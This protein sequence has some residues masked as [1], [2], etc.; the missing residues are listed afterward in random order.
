MASTFW[1][2][3]QNDART[4]RGAPAVHGHRAVSG[5]GRTGEPAYTLPRNNMTSL[6]DTLWVR[7]GSV[8]HMECFLLG[9]WQLRWPLMT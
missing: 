7:V 1:G 8:G 3:Q 6:V 5:L 2:R 9:R 4:C